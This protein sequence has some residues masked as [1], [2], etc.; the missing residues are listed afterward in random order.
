M[1]DLQNDFGAGGGGEAGEA[2]GGQREASG[3][4]GALKHPTPPQN[5][6]EVRRGAPVKE[7]GKLL[8][9]AKTEEHPLTADSASAAGWGVGAASG[10]GHSQLSPRLAGP[11]CEDGSELEKAEGGPATSGVV[12]H[13]S[14]FL[15][16]RKQVSWQLLDVSPAPSV[17]YPLPDAPHPPSKMAR[18]N[19]P[20]S[21]LGSIFKFF[22]RD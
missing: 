5:S 12:G 13:V 20:S 6:P 10:P 3:E 21:H 18:T 2:V 11:S 7:L 4:P 17:F 15:R 1:Q 8:V 22:C 19:Q 9:V 16:K 14:A